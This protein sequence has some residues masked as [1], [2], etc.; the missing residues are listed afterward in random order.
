MALSADV[1]YRT[2][3]I[4]NEIRVI[5]AGAADTLFKGAMVNVGTDG[6][7]KVAADVTAEM[8]FGVVV[9][10]VIAAGANIE[11]VRV[12]HGIVKIAHV[13]AAQTDAL[14]CATDAS[15]LAGAGANVTAFGI[16]I[17]FETDVLIIDTRQ[18]TI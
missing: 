13:G 11:D 7:L 15:T 14:F 9:E 5:K 17:G 10:Q 8:P 3:G 18:K 16:C 2:K 12:E 1:E 6:L 4:K